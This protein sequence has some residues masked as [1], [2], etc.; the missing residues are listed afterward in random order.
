M[1]AG[2]ITPAPA[3]ERRKCEACSLIDLCRPKALG[4]SRPVEQWLTQ[5]IKE[6]A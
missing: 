5:A 1:I 3:Y 2:G 6:E 4:R